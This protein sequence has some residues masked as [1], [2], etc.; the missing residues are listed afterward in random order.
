MQAPVETYSTIN[1]TA[2]STTF[3]VEEADAGGGDDAQEREGDDGD[4]GSD[5]EGKKLQHPEDSHHND[6]IGASSCKDSTGV[7]RALATG[8]T[9]NQLLRWR[10]LLVGGTLW[11]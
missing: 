3:H 7:S 6:D 2:I 4:E 10:K 9:T 5:G 8:L 1:T 11:A